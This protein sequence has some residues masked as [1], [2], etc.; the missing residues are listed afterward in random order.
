[1]KILQIGKYYY[2]HM[3]GIENHLHILSSELVR[4]GHDVTVLVSN[5][6]NKYE[7]DSISGVKVFRYPE[8]FRILNAPISF[9]KKVDR[10]YFDI[11][12]IHLPNPIA[13]IYALFNSGDNLVVTYHSDIIKSSIVGKILN[14]LYTHLF[15]KPLLNKA[16]K[17]LATSPNY[18]SGSSILQKYSGK[19]EIVP[20][21][22]DLDIFNRDANRGIINI[23]KSDYKSKKILLF[24]GRLVPYKGL[25]YLIS[26]M[27]EVVSEFRETKL[28]IVGDGSLMTKLKDLVFRLK[29]NDYVE[30]V[31]GLHNTK[32]PPYYHL[33]D[34]FVLPSVY[35]AEA[36]GIVQLEAMACGK[37]IISTNVDGSGISFVNQNNKTG[38]VVKPRDSNS[39]SAAI[40]KLLRDSKLREAFGKNG[41]E[42]V[43]KYFSKQVMVEKILGVYE[44]TLR[45]LKGI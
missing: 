6:S 20:Y 11:I 17:I 10:K 42:R 37:P 25:D 36:F 40:K 27:P 31:S 13:S 23:L 22:I 35:K 18:V 38:I 44:S 1:M 39:L 8:F 7:E 3:G 16:K 33:S 9:F 45:R 12:H 4:L 34:I 26:A 29:L 14:S 2:P 19:V 32:T 24:V 41:K 5:D 15:L 21:G 30:F 28:I 43:K